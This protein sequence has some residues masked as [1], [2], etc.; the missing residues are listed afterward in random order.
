MSVELLDFN[1]FLSFCCSEKVRLHLG[2]KEEPNISDSEKEETFNVLQE[3]DFQGGD[4]IAEQSKTREPFDLKEKRPA[5]PLSEA[6]KKYSSMQKA[7]SFINQITNE[8]IVNFF[9]ARYNSAFRKRKGTT[10]SNRSPLWVERKGLFQG[11][12]RIVS[13]HEA[14]VLRAERPEGG[15]N[16]QT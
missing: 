16:D 10:N 5:P 1:H 9:I 6:E 14:E 3:L 13:K 11:S 7:I 12:D 4:D 8:I 2:I 15:P